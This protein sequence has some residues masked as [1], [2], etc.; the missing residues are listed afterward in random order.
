MG[1]LME[2]VDVVVIG[3]G[4]AG[5]STAAELPRDHSV[6]VVEMESTPAH[7]ATGRSA[8]L[9]IPTYGPPNVRR[10][11]AATA[12]FFRSDNEGRSRTALVSPRTVIYVANESHRAHLAALETSMGAA[13]GVLEP[14]DP[15]ECRRRVPALREDWVIGG[16]LDHDALDIDVAAT[17]A[18]FRS[19]LH[20]RGGE[21]RPDHRVIALTKFGSGWEVTTTHGSLSAGMVVNAA[22]A[23][24]DEIAALAEI[25]PLGFVPKR[26]TMGIGPVAAGQD[27]GEHFVAHV[28]M[29]FYFGREHGDVMFSPGDETPSVPADA[30]PEEIDLALAIERINEA[31]TLGVRS[32][33]QSWAGLR[34]FSP[35]GNLVVGPDPSD[36]TFIWCGGQG[37]Y[38]IHTSAATALATAALARGEKLPDQLTAV[39]LTPHDLL[40]DRLR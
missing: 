13:G 15:A 26:R 21:L 36:P 29:D 28:S 33:R 5:F 35:D 32:V 3:A 4:I 16:G 24:V 10:L 1:S 31:T 20:E 40:P 7:H 23:W 30:R 34:T 22:G 9:Y 38:G 19:M 39:G 37:G 18:T 27:P 6:I 14:I 17:V 11:T 25:A 12:E 8:A 2:T